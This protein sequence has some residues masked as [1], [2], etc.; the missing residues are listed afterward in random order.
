MFFVKLQT[1]IIFAIIIETGQILYKFGI[2]LNF[3]GMQFL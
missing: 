1:V 2:K 3:F